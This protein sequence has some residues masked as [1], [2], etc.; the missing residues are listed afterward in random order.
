LRIPISEKQQIDISVEDKVTVK[1]FEDMIKPL[2]PKF[3]VQYQNVQNG[4]E[5]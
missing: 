3:K 5:A 2:C 1:E 4:G